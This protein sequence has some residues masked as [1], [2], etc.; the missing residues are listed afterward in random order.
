M[1]LSNITTTLSEMSLKIQVIFLKYHNFLEKQDALPASI[2]Q[3]IDRIEIRITEIQREI[4][5]LYLTVA[6][7]DK[8]QL[9]NFEIKIAA[10]T[11]KLGD[12]IHA[13]ATQIA[14][15]KELIRKEAKEL[16]KEGKS[17]IN[18]GLRKVVITFGG[19]TKIEIISTYYSRKGA[20]GKRGKGCYPE[21]LLVGIRCKCTSRCISLVCGAAVALG[22]YEEAAKVLLNHG[23]KVDQKSIPK[24]L[25][26]LASRVRMDLSQEGGSNIL[27]GLEGKQVVI[28]T[29]GGR[30]RTR[31]RK[32]GPKTSKG[33]NHFHTDWKEPKLFVIYVPNSEGRMD[34]N[35]LPII[36]GEISGPDQIFKLLESYLS[37]INFEGVESVLFV[38]DGATWIWERVGVLFEKLKAKG[39]KCNFYQLIDFYHAAQ[40]LNDFAKLI[41]TWSGKKR[42]AWVRKQKNK[43][44]SGSIDEVLESMQKSMKGKKK[45]GLKKEYNYFVKNKERMC[46]SKI[47]KLG[48]PIGSGAMESAVRRII[49]LRMKSPCVFWTIEGANSMIV[50]RSYFKTNRWEFLMQATYNGELME[51]AA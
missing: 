17:H 46:Y 13:K 7:L 9:M 26:K 37:R 4:N 38:A 30:V 2:Q 25:I 6:Y 11:Q 14:V 32:R 8:S 44:K 47:Q 49:N 20:A 33:R 48:L 51:L 40:H 41:T 50:L 39:L 15:G 34:P 23:I 42:K 35:Y 43:L 45:K 29:D 22:S 19:G 16:M 36:D 12:L 10:L 28:S 5:F 21:F 31:R 3:N 27:D 24:L 18:K 1:I